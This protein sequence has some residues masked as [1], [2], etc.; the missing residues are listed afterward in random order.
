MGIQP[1]GT[2]FIAISRDAALPAEFLDTQ[3]HPKW[4]LKEMFEALGGLG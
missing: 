2:P 3:L 1:A 4:V